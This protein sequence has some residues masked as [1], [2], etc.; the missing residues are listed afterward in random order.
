MYDFL[1]LE[2]AVIHPNVLCFFPVVGI[3][4]FFFAHLGC[5]ASILSAKFEKVG[6]FYVLVILLVDKNAKKLKKPI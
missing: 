2:T 3:G 6:T 4:F 5:Q 1:N